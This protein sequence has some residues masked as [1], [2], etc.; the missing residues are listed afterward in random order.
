M[1]CLNSPLFWI[2]PEKQFQ[3]SYDDLLNDILQVQKVHKYLR[4]SDT[5]QLY[6]ELLA[7]MLSKYE[8]VLLDRDWSSA[9]LTNLGITDDELDVS[10]PMDAQNIES[11]DR[12][13][14]LVQNNKEWK[15]GFFTSG[16]TGRPK[17]IA[18]DLSVLSRNVKVGQRFSE[19]RW[20]FCYNP[21]HFAGIQVFL[22]ALY[23]KNPMINLF[24]I[25]Y[26]VAENALNTYSIT[27]LSATPTYYRTLYGFLNG[28][29]P[30]VERLTFGGEMFDIQIADKLRKYFPN[31]RI[32][33]VYASTELGSILA[34]KGNSLKIPDE[35]SDRIRISK[36]GELEVHKSLMGDSVDE[37]FSTGDLVVCKPDGTLEFVSRKSE[38]INVGGYKVNPHEV[39]ELILSVPNVSDV[40][41]YGRENKVTGKLIVADVALIDMNEDENVI[42][43]EI[44]H[45]LNDKL[46][47]WKIP[48][49][50]KFVDSI[51]RTRTC[52][53]VRK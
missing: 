34:G 14:T 48:R 17:Y 15:L 20:G 13:L 6:V 11:I 26:S 39:E 53:K 50:I 32:T 4:N 27:H 31:A 1:A 2:E 7:S 47:P 46:Q 12:F 19:N 45:Y 44:L 42:E 49:I 33:N 23:N 38:M 36:D 28:I 24:N 21:T 10:Y 52:K 35:F 22:Q 43:S 16:T 41:V 25:N 40:R 37:W 29:Y 8:F 18:H 9:E 30:K 5:Y 3:K 51:D